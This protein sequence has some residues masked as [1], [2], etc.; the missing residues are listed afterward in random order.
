[1]Y[2]RK[3]LN[4]I[5]LLQE[6]LEFIGE[7]LLKFYPSKYSLFTQCVQQQQYSKG[8]CTKLDVTPVDSADYSNKSSGSKQ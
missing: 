2:M 6:D 8:E 7:A 5:I 3:Y 1:M 4:I